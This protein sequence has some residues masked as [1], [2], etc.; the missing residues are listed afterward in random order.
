[1]AGFER[2][3]A[4]PA[5][6]QEA[7]RIAGEVLQ[8]VFD[9][10]DGEPGMGA[11]VVLADA[12]RT[13]KENALHAL[14]TQLALLTEAGDVARAEAVLAEYRPVDLCADGPKVLL[15]SEAGWDAM[16]ETAS[17]P[18]IQF[19]KGTALDHFFGRFLVQR[20]LVA[21]LGKEKGGKSFFLQWLAWEAASQGRNVLYVEAGDSSEPE[22][23]E[24]LAP[25]ILGRPLEAGAYRLP[26][27]VTPNGRQTPAVAYREEK[28]REPANPDLLRI[29]RRR[30]LRAWGG[31][32]LEVYC[33]PT[34]TVKVSQVDALIADRRRRGRVDD[35][36]VVDYADILAADNTKLDR[37][38]QI[39]ETWRA[40]RAVAQRHDCL[41]LTA[42]QARREYYAEWVLKRDAVAEDKRKLA[43]VTLMAGINQTDGERAAGV[44][45][46]NAVA[47]RRLRFGEED[48][49]FCG[50]NFDYC[51]PIIEATF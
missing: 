33:R 48:C 46:L 15:D 5:A 26:T 6:D 39:D 37:R 19:P 25:R 40:L 47:G 16:W 11:D 20:G 36:V 14:H 4:A 10:F 32:R 42:T 3:C 1:M 44:V 9:R 38:D 18:V 41:V 34:G 50:G 24:R 7:A 51:N 8:Q 28:F 2:H 30:L 21:F 45:R 23:R 29:A 12:A 35:V 22:L 17:R 27:A 49:L 31:E 43:H 13:F